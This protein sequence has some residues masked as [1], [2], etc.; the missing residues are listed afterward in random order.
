M[1]HGHAPKFNSSK[2]YVTWLDMKGR[3]NRESNKDY[4][5]YGGR[6]ITYCARWEHFENFL[7]DMGEKPEGLELDRKDNDGDYCIEN[8]RWTTHRINRRNSSHTILTERRVTLLKA[9]LRSIKSKTPKYTAYRVLGKLFGVSEA[10]VSLIATGHKWK[11]V[12]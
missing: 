7:A 4:A 5:R 6:G 11:D 8:C 2:T 12:L 10:T 1:S 3:C 9:L